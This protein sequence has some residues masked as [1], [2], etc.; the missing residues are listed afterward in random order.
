MNSENQK[1]A[2]TSSASP[3][4]VL[5]IV[6]VSYLI[7]VLDI[8]IVITGLPEIRQALGFSPIGLSWVQNAY[9]LCF[10][11]FLLLAARTG[12][13]LGRKRMLIL[14]LTLFTAS[15]FA[16]GIAGTP[17][18]LIG[19]RAVQGVG[20]AILAPTVLSLIATT[21]P[22]GPE[23][24]KALA[25]YSMVAGAGASLGLVLGGIFADQLSWRIGFFM[26]VPIGIGL[27]MAAARLLVESKR[28]GGAFDV[29][30][31]I[32]STLG[33]G[34]LVYGIVR[35]AE[36]GWS[37]S[38]TRS[39]LGLSLVLLALFVF[40]EARVRQPILPLRLFASRER[41][42]AY[43]AR[44]LFLGAM[45]SFFFFSTQ[46][47]QLVLGFSPLQAGI[48]F[49]PMTIPTF[50]AAMIL[51]N[52]TRRLGNAG[53]CVLPWRLRRPACSGWGRPVRTPFSLRIS[54]C[55]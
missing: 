41:S 7:I 9:L 14:G 47:M 29:L 5:A 55:R 4:A 38:L 20:A 32:C 24:T 31:A 45:V 17:A 49:L 23:R 53:C 12:D 28:T 15:S 35:S 33:M 39:A 6:L 52:L 43:A 25:Y 21:F 16:I 30:G 50:L 22:D 10:G 11:G 27:I 48:G 36:A 19:A 3:G 34:A 26:N 42:G 37:D 44:M 1:L 13:I 18:W 8:S 51:P 40:N 54:P 2:T 46:Y